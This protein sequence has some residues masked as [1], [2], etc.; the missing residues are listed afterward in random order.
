MAKKYKL[1][2]LLMALVLVSSL[3]APAALQASARPAALHPALAEL[4]AADPDQSV[5]VIVIKAGADDRAEDYVEQL[6]GTIYHDLYMINAFAAEL[7][8][9]AATRLGKHASVNWV[10]LDGP[11]NFSVENNV[12]EY[13]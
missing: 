8:A 2:Q 11:T 6:G 1:I 3:L 7:S 12:Q 4:A 13:Y 10:T 5:R 9:W